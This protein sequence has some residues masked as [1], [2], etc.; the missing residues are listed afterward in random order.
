M[1][2]CNREQRAQRCYVRS[3]DEAGV[4]ARTTETCDGATDD[5]RTRRWSCGAHQG[6]NLEDKDGGQEDIFDRVE[7]E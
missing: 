4:D 6:T 2:D 7:G 3:H 5:E 1:S